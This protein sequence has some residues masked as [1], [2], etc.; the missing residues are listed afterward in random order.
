VELGP[1]LTPEQVA[2][3]RVMD[4]ARQAAR[5]GISPGVASGDQPV[6]GVRRNNERDTER[7]MGS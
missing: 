6:P 3:A 5:T 7:G 1:V 2:M 4:T